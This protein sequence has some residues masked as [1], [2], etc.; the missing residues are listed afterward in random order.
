MYRIYYLDSNGDGFDEYFSTKNAQEVVDICRNNN[1]VD[2]ILDVAKVVHNWKWT[3]YCP[4]EKYR[5]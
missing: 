1:D 3:T 5:I 2:E 4:I